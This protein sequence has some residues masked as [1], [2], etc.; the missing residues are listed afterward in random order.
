MSSSVDDG[1]RARAEDAVISIVVTH[2]V[3]CDCRNGRFICRG[4]LLAG[5][6]NRE[7]GQSHGAG[8]SLATWRSVDVGNT[9]DDIAGAEGGNNVDSSA[10][11]DLI[12]RGQG[13]NRGLVVD[14]LGISAGRNGS[15]PV[16]NDAIETV[17]AGLREDYILL[18][19]G[20]GLWGAGKL[21]CIGVSFFLCKK[22]KKGSESHLRA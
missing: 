21:L 16:V 4:D 15:R 3:E 9:S 22:N 12:S 7:A 10:G 19:V 6:V 8:N 20:S 11:G 14:D 2:D 17:V 18:P 1:A 13:S 5:A